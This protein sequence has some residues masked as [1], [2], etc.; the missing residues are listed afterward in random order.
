MQW[1]QNFNWMCPKITFMYDH[2][3]GDVRA[4]NPNAAWHKTKAWHLGCIFDNNW[5]VWGRGR[6]TI[7]ERH[8]HGAGLVDFYINLTYS[9]NIDDP[10]YS[11][12]LSSCTKMVTCVPRIPMLHDIRLKRGIWA[13]FSITIGMYEGGGML[14]FWNVIVMV[15]VWLTFISIYPKKSKAVDQST[16]NYDIF[17]L[18]EARAISDILQ[19]C[20]T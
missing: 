6:V 20:F 17:G 1:L 7:L 3:D 14:R 19:S 12:I 8:S 9:L 2:W 5:D 4:K 10:L 15:L 16:M 11:Q 18:G 13:A